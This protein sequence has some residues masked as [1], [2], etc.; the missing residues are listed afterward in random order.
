MRQANQPIPRRTARTGV[1]GSRPR[2][3][4]FEL[5]LAPEEAQRVR[6]EAVRRGLPASTYARMVVLGG[7]DHAEDMLE[8]AVQ[9][10]TYVTHDY[11]RTVPRAQ[12][13]TI[14]HAVV[15][16]HAESNAFCRQWG[17]V[18]LTRHREDV[19]VHLSAA[20]LRH[21]RVPTYEP[22]HWPREDRQEAFVDR[23]QYAPP[24]LHDR[25]SA[26]E[27]VLDKARAEA[28]DEAAGR[29]AQDRPGASTL[30]YQEAQPVEHSQEM[31]VGSALEADISEERG[32]GHDVALEGVMFKPDL[33]IEKGG[34]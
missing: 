21:D 34:I 16:A 27:L 17:T 26:S 22:A 18:A 4:R 24:E 15:A 1:E 31:G 30:D 10:Y 29:L 20:G 5:L 33:A 8:Q 32:P 2:T 9:R 19:Q 11:A 7:I 13:A 3:V 25:S 28:L 14:D 12:G 23:G 6:R